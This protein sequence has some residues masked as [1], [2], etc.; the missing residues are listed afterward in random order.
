MRLILRSKSNS[1]YINKLLLKLEELRAE[2]KFCVTSYA[3]RDARAFVGALD[4]ALKHV[5]GLMKQPQ[6]EGG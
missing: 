4:K 2:L 1:V 6:G 3:P 5:Q